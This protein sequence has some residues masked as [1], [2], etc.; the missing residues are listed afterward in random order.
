MFRAVASRCLKTAVLPQRLPAA[1]FQAVRFY[2]GFPALTRDL[3][4]ERVIELLEGYDKVAGKEITESSSFVQDL[5]LD[6]LDVVEVVMEVE[7]EFNI[8]IPDHEADTLKTVGQTID[9]IVS[10]PDAC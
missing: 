3:A 2:A 1:R 6:S 4:K 7:H 8:Q 5:N 10:Q 9:Y